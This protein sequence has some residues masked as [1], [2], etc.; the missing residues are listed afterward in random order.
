MKKRVISLVVMAFMLATLM[1]MGM[2]FAAQDVVLAYEEFDD[3]TMETGVTAKNETGATMTIENGKVTFVNNKTIARVYYDKNADNGEVSGSTV[4]GNIQIEFTYSQDTFPGYDSN[5]VYLYDGDGTY[6]SM[7]KRIG[8]SLYWNNDSTSDNFIGTLSANTDHEIKFVF[9]TNTGNFEC[10][11]DGVKKLDNT[12]AGASALPDSIK[13]NGMRYCI[14][15][16]GNNMN[17]NSNSTD[18]TASM[19]YFKVSMPAADPVLTAS[20]PAANATGVAET[21]VPTLT[22]DQDINP[23]SFKDA[24]LIGNGKTVTFKTTYGNSGTNSV[25]F[26]LDDHL[27]GNTTYT[28][29]LPASA[30]TADGQKIPSA[31]ISFTTAE[32]AKRAWDVK[33]TFTGSFGASGELIANTS[34]GNITYDQNYALDTITS[35]NLESGALKNRSFYRYGKNEDGN[36]PETLSKGIVELEYDIYMTHPITN[37]TNYL[38]QITS[39]R[40][41]YKVINK[42]D[43]NNIV[44]NDGTK[45]TSVFADSS[46]EKAKWVRVRNLLNFDEGKA[47]VY[48]N[49]VAVLT[50][51]TIPNDLEIGWD[52][53]LMLNF[54]WTG[55]VTLA[56]NE[57]MKMGYDNI[58]V[59]RLLNPTVTCKVTNGVTEDELTSVP[60][61]GNIVVKGTVKDVNTDKLLV[62]VA[63]YDENENMLAVNYAPTFENNEFTTNITAKP[64]GKTIKVF[65][66]DDKTTAHPMYPA[67]VIPEN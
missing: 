31:S 19:K 62:C 23:D 48:V 5:F 18:V 20:V 2:A 39:K 14:V 28:L 47:T 58:R 11:F 8:P 3:S 1:P 24:T 60:T 12:K 56:S 46:N 29:T 32:N 22:Y 15:Y 38:L 10:W 67:K 7:C 63:L 61:T 49:D 9:N 52:E 4:K 53:G 34:N 41:N 50:D 43:K 6:W 37:Q 54:G 65:V 40:S 64:N 26:L 36:K 45:I 51:K 30:A 57:T 33:E 21:V 59:S 27:E 17:A 13:T 16:M 35:S 42:F 55:T 66:W 44:W 25:A